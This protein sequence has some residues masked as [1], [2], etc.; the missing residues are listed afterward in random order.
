M[1][2]SNLLSNQHMNGVILL[3]QD[4]MT[5]AT[6]EQSAPQTNGDQGETENKGGPQEANKVIYLQLMSS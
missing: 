3:L 5:G 6:T 4:D 2:F 1:C